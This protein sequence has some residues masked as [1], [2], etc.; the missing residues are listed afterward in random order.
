MAGQRPGSPTTTLG[1]DNKEVG[2]R[3][4]INKIFS[5]FLPFLLPYNQLNIAAQQT[6]KQRKYKKSTAAIDAAGEN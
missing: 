4:M 6:M 5:F 2:I 1:D 3:M